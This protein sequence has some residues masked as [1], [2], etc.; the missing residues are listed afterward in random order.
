MDRPAAP[1]PYVSALRPTCQVSCLPSTEARVRPASSAHRSPARAAASGAEIVPSRFLSVA[2]SSWAV[3]IS[4]P[5][6]T[7][8]SSI[9][10][11]RPGLLHADRFDGR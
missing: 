11:G 1:F 8:V 10:S 5:S 4:A 2:A 7:A 9:L 3:G 6:R